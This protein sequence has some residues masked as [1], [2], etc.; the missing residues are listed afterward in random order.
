MTSDAR[1]KAV[2]KII[3]RQAKDAIQRAYDFGVAEGEARMRA[4][5]V[6]LMSGAK[7]LEPPF[8]L[9]SH[10]RMPRGS[11]FNVVRRTVAHFT[12]GVTTSELARE[13][14]LRR[15][16]TR[17]ALNKLRANGDVARR[18]GK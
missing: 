15:S 3:S 5:F 10:R 11:V 7:S 8:A 6:A 16:S 9:S 14:G 1:L 13:C 4:Q 17:V 2:K 12:N 18:E